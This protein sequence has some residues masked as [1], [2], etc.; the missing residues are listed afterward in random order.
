MLETSADTASID[1]APTALSITPAEYD[2]LVD[3]TAA[4]VGS[5]VR[6][7]KYVLP[8]GA[9]L[10]F[11]AEEILSEAVL[12]ACEKANEYD[13]SRPVVPWILRIAQNK[14][15]SRYRDESR[16]DPVSI[17]ELLDQSDDAF[18]VLEGPNEEARTDARLDVERMLDRLKPSDADLLRHR[19][20]NDDEIAKIA[21]A[22]GISENAVE[23]RLSRARTAARK[24]HR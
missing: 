19:Y 13:T 12:T 6:S 14:L 10:A 15:L 2:D 24:L 17:D 8:H 21:R 22:L 23:K 16:R 5:A 11:V 9:S 1:D 18:G 3:S 20:L 4:L 7:S